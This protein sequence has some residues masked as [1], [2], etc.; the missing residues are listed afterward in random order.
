MAISLGLGAFGVE[1]EGLVDLVTVVIFWDVLDGFVGWHASC[2]KMLQC[3]ERLHGVVDS[4]EDCDG[5]SVT[6]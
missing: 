6:N 5:D 3:L 4:S 2:L 1:A